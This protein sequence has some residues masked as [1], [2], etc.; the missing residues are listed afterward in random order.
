MDA[1]LSVG[2]LRLC[3]QE[4]RI[5]M[6]TSPLLSEHV[7]ID[8]VSDRDMNFDRYQDSAGIGPFLPVPG[9]TGTGIGDKTKSAGIRPG[10]TFRHRDFTGI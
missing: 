4:Y 5:T 2:E 6:P 10:L 8:P 7:V 9:L 3:A 1:G